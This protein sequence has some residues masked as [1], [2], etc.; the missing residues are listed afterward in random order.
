MNVF[1]FHITMIFYIENHS[2]SKPQAKESTC[3]HARWIYIG[4][5]P[6]FGGRGVRWSVLVE[7]FVWDGLL[8]L[9]VKISRASLLKSG[10][11]SIVR[12]ST[13]SYKSFC[14]LKRFSGL[15][16]N[17]AVGLF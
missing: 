12:T 17:V 8:F 11:V 10:L 1:C 3:N 2:H 13:I 7:S 16:L 9:C 15:I 4:P 14:Y 6:F 5:H